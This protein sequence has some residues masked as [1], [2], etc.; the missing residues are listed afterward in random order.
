MGDRQPARAFVFETKQPAGVASQ[1]MIA[2]Q[3]AVNRASNLEQLK[4]IVR[5][6]QGVKT[7]VVITNIG[8]EEIVKREVETVK[9][10][11]FRAD[12][13]V[14]IVAI[15]TVGKDKITGEEINRGQL[16]YL[17]CSAGIKKIGN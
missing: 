8:D 16:C 3:D 6:N 1:A 4:Q 9:R 12:G 10:S 15:G 5:D 17:S 13:K 2:S 14:N 7:F 11:I